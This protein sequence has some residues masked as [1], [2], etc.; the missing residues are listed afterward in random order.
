MRSGVQFASVAQGP[1]VKGY[2]LSPGEMD[3]TG[4][5]EKSRNRSVGDKTSNLPRKGDENT[6]ICTC[7]ETNKRVGAAG[8]PCQ[9]A[10]PQARDVQGWDALARGAVLRV[11]DL[12]EARP[13]HLGEEFPRVREARGPRRRGERRGV[14]GQSGNP[15]ARDPRGPLRRH[16]GLQPL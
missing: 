9:G 15:E 10:G 12:P 13:L 1:L 4:D 14:H 2:S 8:V 7:E 16:G 11:Q 6:L 5:S 3:V